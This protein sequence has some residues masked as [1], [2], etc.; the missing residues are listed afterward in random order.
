MK[1]ILFVLLIVL[2]VACKKSSTSNPVVNT[3]TLPPQYGTPFANV[4]DRRDAAIYQVNIGQFSASGNLQGITQRLDSLQ[5][6]GI[7]VVYLMPIYPIGVLKSFGSPYCVKDYKSV[8]SSIGTLD[9]LRNLV[10]KAH[11]LNMVVMLDWVANHT[12]WDNS[13]I[14][15]KSWYLQDVSGNILS[16]PGTTW[17]DVAQLDF[18]NPDMRLA[19]INAMKYWVYAAN[20]DGFRCDYAD[21]PLVN[22]WQQA[23]D[24]LHNITTHKLLMLAEGNRAT[25]FSVAGFDYNFGFSFFNNLLT[26]YGQNSVLSI[27]N[28][29]SLEYSAATGTQ[30]MVRYLSNNDV[31]Y[32]NGTPVQLFGGEQGALAA[33]VVVAYMKGVPMIYTGQEVGTATPLNYPTGNTKVNWS[34]NPSVLA[35]YKTIMAFRNSSI[36]IRQGQLTSYSTADVCAFTRQL[37]S[38]EVLVID[39]LRNQNITYTLPSTIPTTGWTDAYTK[40]SVTL[41]SQ[42]ILQPYSYMV[43]KNY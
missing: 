21:G 26:V 37:A 41:P 28:T 1:N 20:V 25:N 8:N 19:M 13:W 32:S 11:S 33:F 12:S 10:A 22:F 6:L 36:A 14:T 38:E 35:Q 9:D 43:L 5:S 31:D 18:N 29:N 30:Q 17:T 2:I 4:P 27:D 40:G 15:N 7:N 16:P 39:N 34:A 23:I 42:V 24:S 3:D